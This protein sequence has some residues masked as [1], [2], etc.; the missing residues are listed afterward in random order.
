MADIEQQLRED[1]ALR[2]AA[3][4]LVTAG[5]DHVKGDM[6]EKGV[7]SRLF[8]RVKDGAAEMAES[9]ADYASSNRS[10]V[11]T[12]IAFGLLAFVGWLFRDQLA[13]AINAALEEAGELESESAAQALTED[14]SETPESPHD[15]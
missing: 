9:S 14:P 4:R 3:K 10:Q 2:D 12:G 1:R 15:R 8:E 13:D 6:A 7:G 5:I 11:G